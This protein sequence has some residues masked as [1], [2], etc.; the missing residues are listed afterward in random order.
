M[1][2]L[3]LS[4]A[5]LIVASFSSASVAQAQSGTGTLQFTARITPTGARPEPVRQ[6]TFYILTKSYSDITK[7]VEAANPVPPRDR[8]IEELKVSPELKKWLT[9]HEVFDL[10]MPGLDKLLTP[11]DIIHTPEFLLA[12]QRSNSGGVTD[13]IPKP[14]YAEADK[15]KNPDRYKRMTDEYLAALKKFIQAHPETVSGVELQLDGVN[16]QFKWSKLQNERKKKVQRFAPE[17]AQ[18]KF[19]AG[20]VDTDLEGRAALSGLAPGEYWI[21]TLNLDADAG[22]VRLRW[23]ASVTIAAGQTARVELSNLNGTDAHA[24]STP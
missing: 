10:T 5:A 15:T 19:L 24:E 2:K 23:D 14:K 7:E 20:K 8:F 6:F 21:S 1:R 17:V 16:P 3:I 4:G 11:D 12:Y 13:G 18:S 22:D 9:D